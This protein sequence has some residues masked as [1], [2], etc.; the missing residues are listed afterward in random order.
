VR[1]IDIEEL[2]PHLPVDWEKRAKEALEE[3]RNAPP[4]KRSATVNKHARLWHELGNKLGLLSDNKCWYCESREIRSDNPVD[5]FRPKNRVDGCVGH[6]GYWWLAFDWHNYRFSCTYCNSRRKDRIGGTTGGKH[7]AFPILDE[8]KRV[9]SETDPI[10]REDP[11]LLDPTNRA[12]PGC[13]W[14][15]EDGRVVEKYNERQQPVLFRRA[16]TSIE[17]YHLN[18]VATK[19]VRKALFRK[20]RQLVDNGKVYFENWQAGNQAA[21]VGLD[22]VIGDLRELIN[23]KT[24]FSAAAR[25]MLLGLRDAEHPW[26][27]GVITGA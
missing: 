13:L 10:S 21:Q 2:L 9:Y 6:D 22:S 19:E 27:D 3:V 12:D 4:D 14:F 16:C 23:K 17:L 15:E 8:A 7:D 20:I 25:A 24:G 5:H 18:H 11:E 26:I 1:H